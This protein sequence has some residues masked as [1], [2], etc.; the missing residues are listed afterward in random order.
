MVTVAI[1]A[2]ELEYL[3]KILDWGRSWSRYIFTD[4]DC[5]QKFLPIATSTPP[6][7]PSDSDSTA[8]VRI[9]T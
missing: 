2:L 9:I 7:I 5:T 6:K 4:S 1:R 8:L 3:V